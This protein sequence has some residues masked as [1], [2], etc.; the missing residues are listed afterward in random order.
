MPVLARQLRP[1]PVIQSPDDS[2]QAPMCAQD[3]CD[4]MIA[5][6]AVVDQFSEFTFFY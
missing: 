1:L 6:E 3:I 5:D 4:R 2:P